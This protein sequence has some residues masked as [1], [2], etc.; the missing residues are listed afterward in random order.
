MVKLC[1]KF[2][3]SLS[4][5]LLLCAPAAE[6]ANFKGLSFVGSYPELH[7]TVQNVFFP[8]MA[9]AEQDL[10]NLSFSYFASNVLYPDSE[11]YTVLTDGRVD[12]GVFRPAMFPGMLNGVTLLNIPALT[13]NAV[14]GSLVAKDMIEQFPELKKEFPK[15]SELFTTWAS[16]SYQIHTIDPVKNLD[17][18]KGKKILCWDTEGVE[19]LRLLGA[20]PIKLSP[21]DTYLS[22]SKGMAD[23]V[24]CPLAP[25]RS[26]KITD[27]AK[28]HLMANLGTAVF[29]FPAFGGLWDEF[30]PEYQEYLKKAGQDMTLAA[31]KSLED[32]A[33][34]DLAWMKNLGHEFYYLSDEDK[35]KLKEAFA[36]LESIWIEKAKKAGFDNAEEMLKVAK[37]KSAH[38]QAEFEKGTYG[39]Y[40]TN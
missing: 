39:D 26:Y 13:P 29:I 15:D 40:S 16:A 14:V 1:K 20:N 24:L 12:F 32:G 19:M 30:P 2:I 17:E 25:V 18:L 35:V 5:A 37:E 10:D 3:M 28:Y 36:P 31:G 11:A 4:A 7:P 27:V 23:G 33:K 8:F 34:T 6:A 21:T 22:L 38:Y 9:K